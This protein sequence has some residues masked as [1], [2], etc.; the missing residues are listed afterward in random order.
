[1]Q[2]KVETITGR[3]N[4]FVKP[5]GAFQSFSLLAERLIRLCALV[6]AMAGVSVGWAWDA[7]TP[8]PNRVRVAAG[9]P[10]GGEG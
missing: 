5:V 9:L 4:L 7:S 2:S 1:M 10:R 6:A 3:G 8:Q